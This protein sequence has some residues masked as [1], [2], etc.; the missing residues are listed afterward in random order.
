MKAVRKNTEISIR[1]R[2]AHVTFERVVRHHLGALMH[3]QEALHEE[4]K[5]LRAAVQIYAEVVRRLQ[6]TGPRRA[7]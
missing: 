1:A 5:Q 7:A 2:R 6:V 3:E 4:V